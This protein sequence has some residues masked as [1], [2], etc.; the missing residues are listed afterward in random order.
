MAGPG[1]VSRVLLAP[2]LSFRRRREI[3]RLAEFRLDAGPYPA[4]TANYHVFGKDQSSWL[5]PSYVAICLL[6]TVTAT[7]FP[8]RDCGSTPAY[9]FARRAEPRVPVGQRK[10]E[11]DDVSC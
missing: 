5:R 8:Q 1:D 11:L 2:G 4:V 9:L 3:T 7:A 10:E 6:P